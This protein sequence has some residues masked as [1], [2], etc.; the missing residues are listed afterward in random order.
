[1]KNTSILSF[2]IFLTACFLWLNFQP[3][4]TGQTQLTTNNDLPFFEK[5]TKGWF[6]M[7]D[8]TQLAVQNLLDK[9]HTEL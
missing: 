4:P 6:K 1:M 5:E 2:T 3:Q 7:K 9:H 8:N